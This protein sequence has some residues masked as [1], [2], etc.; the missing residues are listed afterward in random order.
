MLASFP[1]DARAAPPV[2]RVS[3]GGVRLGD[4]VVGVLE[5]RAGLWPRLKR[6]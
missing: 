2:A 4:A 6:V 5:R 1:E 3:G